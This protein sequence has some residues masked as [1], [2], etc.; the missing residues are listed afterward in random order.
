MWYGAA[1]RGGDHL[2]GRPPGR[3]FPVSG[4]G[5]KLPPPGAG[6]GRRGLHRPFHRCRQHTVLRDTLEPGGPGADRGVRLDPHGDERLQPGGRAGRPGRRPG[7]DRDQDGGAWWPWPTVTS[8]PWSLAT[9]LAGAVIGFLV[10]NV[11]P[12]RIFMGDG[13]SQFLGYALAIVSLR[14][15]QKGATAVAILVPLLLLGVP[16]LD[17]ATTIMRRAASGSVEGGVRGLVKKV[18][19]ADRGH[20]HHNLVDIGLSPGRAVI[21]LHGIGVLFACSALPD[22]RRQQRLPGPVHPGRLL[23]GRGRHQAGAVAGARRGRAPGLGAALAVYSRFRWSLGGVG[24][25]RGASR[26]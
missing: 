15:S 1:R 19:S 4:P 9:A 26:P 14:G 13:G 22:G 5:P 21:A 6:R 12:A 23:R 10:Y 2:P 16:L 25:G 20:L 11:A 8:P 24:S 18:G 7:P 17:L 3:P